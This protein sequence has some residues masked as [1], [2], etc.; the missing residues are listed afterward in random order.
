MP[1]HDKMKEHYTFLDNSCGDLS[2]LLNNLAEEGWI[3]KFVNS[4]WITDQ[5]Q[6]TVTMSKEITDAPT[7]KE[8][9]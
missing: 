2:W 8:N 5:F 6:I 3:I 1:L 4:T 7:R 9:R